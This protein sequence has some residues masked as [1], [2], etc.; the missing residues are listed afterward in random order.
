[1]KQRPRLLYRFSDRQLSTPT[2]VLLLIAYLACFVHLV[3]GLISGDETASGF[4]LGMSSVCGI[5]IVADRFRHPGPPSTHRRDAL[6]QLL[7]I[8]F[9]LWA[10]LGL[11]LVMLA[12]FGVS[13]SEAL[14]LPMALPVLL[15]VLCIPLALR[16]T[17]A[18]RR[19]ADAADKPADSDA[20]RAA[21]PL[22]PP[23]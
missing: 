18:E 22:N 15:W 17:E 13:I 9:H 14:I 2:C 5:W 7:L 19:H 16:E 4:W 6:P 21:K 11:L 1:M 23:A 10:Q 12:S 20:E 8:A 3:I